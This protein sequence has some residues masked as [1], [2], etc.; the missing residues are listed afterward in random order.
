L[1]ALFKKYDKAY[2]IDKVNLEET[3]TKIK[4]AHD[5]QCKSK[6]FDLLAAEYPVPADNLSCDILIAIRDD[7]SVVNDGDKY[8]KSDYNR[9]VE[10]KFSKEE[11]SNF[12]AKVDRPALNTEDF[13]DSFNFNVDLLNQEIFNPTKLDLTATKAGAKVANMYKIFWM[14]LFRNRTKVSFEQFIYNVSIFA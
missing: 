6:S 11:D 5:K 10:N 7:F 12:F 4:E 9:F 2:E 1:S 8:L 14:T 13:L 3:M